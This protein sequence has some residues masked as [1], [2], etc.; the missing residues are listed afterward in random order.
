MRWVEGL[1]AGT[2]DGGR[3][4]GM[5]ARTRTFVTRTTENLL[6]A[7]AEGPAAHHRPAPRANVGE[8]YKRRAV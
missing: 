5:D 6:R 3:D 7:F 1:M 2:P 4:H 8:L